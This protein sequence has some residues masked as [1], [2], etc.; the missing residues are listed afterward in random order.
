MTDTWEPLADR[1]FA[2]Y[3]SVQGHVRT[4]LIDRNLRNHLPEPPADLVDVGGGAGHQALPLARDGY[5][6]T[7]VEPSKEMLRRASVLLAAESA[8]VRKRVMLVRSDAENAFSAVEGRRFAGVMCHAVLQYIDD[9][10]ATLSALAELAHNDGVVSLVVKNQAA[11]VMPPALSGR[12]GEA[13]SAFDR[14]LDTCGLGVSTRADTVEKLGGWLA[15][16][17]VRTV[18]SYGV[19]FF[20]DWW[21]PPDTSVEYPSEDLLSV[22]LEA[23]RRN[24]YRQLGRMF[25]LV[26][27]RD[28]G[29]HAHIDSPDKSA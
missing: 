10:S 12:W 15:Q 28:Y 17:G 1:F 23:S 27:V 8:D 6:V 2:Y 25:H 13:L 26:G 5:R 9:P 29:D 11:V 14:T 3:E 7:I 4:H 16:R 20:T 19:G 24:P 18:A 21:S 22:E